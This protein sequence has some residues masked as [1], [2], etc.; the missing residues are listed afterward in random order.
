MAAVD[1]VHAAL[2][3]EH[4][5]I[6]R[7]LQ[8]AVSLVAARGHLA[9]VLQLPSAIQAGVAPTPFSSM[10]NLKEHFAFVD[11]ATLAQELLARGLAL[12]HEQRRSLPGGKVFW[13]GIFK[14]GH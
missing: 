5:G 2:I 14:R 12:E 10:Q 7:C 4:A 13:L 6:G 11:P 9:V 1:L 3:F 8:N